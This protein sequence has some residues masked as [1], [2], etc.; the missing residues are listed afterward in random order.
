MTTTVIAWAVW[1]LSQISVFGVSLYLLISGIR[2]Y[3]SK[4]VRSLFYSGFAGFGII[5][6]IY[7]LMKVGIL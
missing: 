1:S 5:S 6:V 4:K 7:Q 3:H 2:N